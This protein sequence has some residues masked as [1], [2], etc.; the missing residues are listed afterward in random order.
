MIN[1]TTKPGFGGSAMVAPLSLVLI[2]A[3]SDPCVPLI[4]I[5]ANNTRM[6]ATLWPPIR[7]WSALC[8]LPAGAGRAGN[9]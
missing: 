2:K 3:I 4:A 8:P 5:H 9:S 6:C 7:S 1:P